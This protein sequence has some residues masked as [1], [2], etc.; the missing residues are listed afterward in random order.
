MSSFFIPL[1]GRLD[2]TSSQALQTGLE[3]MLD[4][5]DPA[6]RHLILGLEKVTFLGSAGLRLLLVLHK[7]CL[8]QGGSLVLS[9][10]RHPAHEVL[11]MAGLD[12]VFPRYAHE[13]EARRALDGK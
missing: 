5:L 9:G 7:R 3:R 13:T 1:K 11:Q 6:P 4:S 12:D 10:V 8:A 2:V